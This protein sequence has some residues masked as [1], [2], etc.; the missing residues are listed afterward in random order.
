MRVPEHTS[1]SRHTLI[2]TTVTQQ[3]HIGFTKTP[4][5]G[6]K[7]KPPAEVLR[8]HQNPG[9]GEKEKD[10]HRS[11]FASPKPS[12]GEE[13]SPCPSFAASP[14]SFGARQFFYIG[15]R[16]LCSLGDDMLHTRAL[17]AKRSLEI[18]LCEALRIAENSAA[19]VTLIFAQF[20]RLHRGKFQVPE[21]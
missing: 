5:E 19:L 11:F 10:R 16:G 12:A 21:H 4:G 6:R 20:V 18:A 17:N 8:L 2:E 15:C 7:K 1:S 13:K 14:P 3:E 9:G